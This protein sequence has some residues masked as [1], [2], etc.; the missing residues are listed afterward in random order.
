[1]LSRGGYKIC[2]FK[3]HP[4]S[5]WMCLAIPGKVLEIEGNVAKV[6]FGHGTT[7]EVDIS[8]VDVDVGQFILVH[9]GYAIQV[10]DEREAEETLSLW[11][12]ILESV[13]T[14]PERRG[15]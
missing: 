5:P 8:L 3:V 15:E 12:E 10:L 1:M 13:E 9:V 6:D 2:F 14:G 7:R 4:P 11:R